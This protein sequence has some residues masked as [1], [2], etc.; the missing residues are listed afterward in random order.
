M[1]MWHATTII[2]VKKDNKVAIAGDGQ[3]SL[4]HTVM[5]ATANKIRK[6]NSGKIIAGFAGS[7]ADAFTLFERIEVKLEKHNNHLLRAAVEMSKDWRTDKYLRR[8]EAMLIVADK[9]VLLVLSGQ[10]DVLEPEDNIAAIGSGGNYA[11][12]AAKAFLSNPALSAREIA[13]KSIHIA[14]DIC[15]YTNHNIKIEEL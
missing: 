2:A 10:G 8:L 3:V 15:V 1:K 11:R 7:T 4:G 9:D 13:E 14:A 6:S 5:K 12:A